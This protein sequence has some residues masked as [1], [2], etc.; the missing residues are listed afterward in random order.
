MSEGFGMRSLHPTV[1]LFY[2]A[3]GMAFGM[4][5]FHPL[6]LLCG[7]IACLIVNWHLD[8]GRAWRHWALPIIS[9]LLF[10]MI[11]NP[12]VSHRGRTVWFYLGDAAITMESVAYGITMALS[13]L[14]LLTLFVSY[15]IVLTERKFLYLFAR[16]SPRMALLTMMAAGMVPRLRRRLS[17]L[18]LVQQTR[19]VTVAEGTIAARARSGARLIASLLAWTLD[20]ALQTADSMQARGYGTGPRSSYPAFAFRGR[21]R[22]TAAGLLAFAAIILV[23]W[24]NGS[25]FL[26]I[27]PRLAPVALDSGDC[28]TMAAYL[29]FLLLPLAWEWR[30]RRTWQVS[31]GKM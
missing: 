10:V 9:I 14:G 27:Y 28:W 1:M 11:V 15:R 5:L 3:G 17:T 24:W 26:N 13:L 16:I 23:L 20:D 2:Y 30:D 18:M 8:G 29:S 4:L 22:W 31:S 7:W 25:G 21:D 19:G 12:L 6:I